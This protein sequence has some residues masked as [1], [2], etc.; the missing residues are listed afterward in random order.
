MQIKNNWLL[1]LILIGAAVLRLWNLGSV[2]PH[3]TPDEAAL[4]YNA[5]SISKTGKDEF[6]QTLPIIFKSFGDYKP[7][8]YIYTSVPFVALLGL[9]EFSVRLPSALAGILSVYLIYLITLKLFNSKKLSLASA[10]V[11]AIMPWLIYF[12]RGAWEVNLSLSLTLLGIYLFLKSFEKPKLLLFAA[13]SFALTLLAYQGAKLATGIVV[14][15]LL[16]VYWK[17][18]WRLKKVYL[19]SSIVVGL[20][21]SLPIILSLFQGKTGRLS[22]FSVFSY[23]RPVDYL[24]NF[25]DQGKERVG[26]LGYYLFHSERLNFSRGIMSRYFNHFSGD[27]LFFEGDWSN[28]R[29]SSPNSGMLLL[30]DIVILIF[31]F[32]LI[33]KDKIDKGKLFILL[34]LILSPLPAVLSRDQ[35]HAIRAFNMAIPLVVILG[36][37]YSK[38]SK[39]YFGVTLLALIYFIDSYFIH[40]PKHSSNLW[41]Y[42][43]KQI[44][45]TVTPIQTNYETVKVQRSF[46]QPYIYFLFYQKYD[47]AKYQASSNWIHSESV[48]DVGYVTKLDNIEFAPIDWSLNRGDKGTLF[49][50]DPIRIPPE[51]SRDGDQFKV[52]SEI[53]YLNGRDT[54][55]RIIEVK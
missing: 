47:P 37:G 10:F 33:F 28:P 7:G 14:I 18:V 21:I 29:H 19:Y 48:V 36:M 15:L 49:V 40:L 23:R 55:F 2:P 50:A 43:Y 35:V 42:G 34:W 22:V 26:T 17:E 25:L 38:I 8:L 1:I 45:E 20:V 24:Q 9:N 30:S 41:E 51:D 53:K 4:G 54:A 13:S 11:A 52:I 27:F 16:S 31:G 46:S 39:W 6:G 5:Y 3:L 44:V 32:V 12:S